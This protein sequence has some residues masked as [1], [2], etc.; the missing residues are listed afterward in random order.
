VGV[1]E[2]SWEPTAANLGEERKK[3]RNTLLWIDGEGNIKH[4]Y[5]KLHLFDVEIEGGPILRESEYVHGSLW[6]FDIFPSCL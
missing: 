6:T 2:P 5:Q 3:V 1:H 4:R